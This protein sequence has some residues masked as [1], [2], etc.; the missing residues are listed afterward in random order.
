MGRVQPKTASSTGHASPARGTQRTTGRHPR[1]DADTLRQRS[2]LTVVLLTVLLTGAAATAALA[3]HGTAAMG[4][5]L[6]GALT[7][8]MTC[9][10][11]SAHRA[12][13]DETRQTASP[14]LS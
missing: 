1:P 13:R 2:L 8:T 9:V 6:A 14:R 3:V 11:V 4:L 5:P 7:I 10:I 12:R